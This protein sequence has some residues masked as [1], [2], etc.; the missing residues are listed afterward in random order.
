MRWSEKNFL[1]KSSDIAESHSRERVPGMGRREFSQS[2]AAC[3]SGR[4]AS[5]GGLGVGVF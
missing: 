4:Q 2:G 3:E 1:G 5:G